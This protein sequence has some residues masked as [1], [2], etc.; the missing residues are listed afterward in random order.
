MNTSI[1]Y[2]VISDGKPLIPDIMKISKQVNDNTAIVLLDIPASSGNLTTNIEGSREIFKFEVTKT[3]RTGK[4]TS[5]TRY[6]CYYGSLPSSTIYPGFFNSL[7]K[8][9]TGNVY[10]NPTITNKDGEH[11]FLVVPNYLNIKRVTSAGFNVTM[12][13]PV[14]IAN[15][16]GT[17]KVYITANP[18]TPATWNLVIS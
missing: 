15:Q 14:I 3:G 12:A 16:L 7:T 18:L 5:I 8:V 9:S 13:D 4:S 2:S 1:N 10:F 11:L 6:L 17:F